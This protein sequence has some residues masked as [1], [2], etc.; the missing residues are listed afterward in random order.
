MRRLSCATVHGRQGVLLVSTRVL[1]PS[2]LFLI[3]FPLELRLP[4]LAKEYIKPVRHCLKLCCMDH[5][6]GKYVEDT[7][8][9]RHSN[10]AVLGTK[11]KHHSRR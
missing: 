9:P 4:I 8:P 2:P 10:I 5:A 3:S 1:P 11:N 6:Q 7:E